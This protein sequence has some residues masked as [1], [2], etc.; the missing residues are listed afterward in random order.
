MVIFVESQFFQQFKKFKSLMLYI[1]YKGGKKCYFHVSD[2]HGC[3]LGGRC[4]LAARRKQLRLKPLKA[5]F[6]HVKT[7]IFSMFQG[8]L[9]GC[10]TLFQ[11][12]NILN[13][14]F[15]FHF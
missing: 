9:R 15:S 13:N 3:N 2:H 7:N 12:K 10:S 4:L 6:F 8:Q 5:F 11:G 1:P 14:I